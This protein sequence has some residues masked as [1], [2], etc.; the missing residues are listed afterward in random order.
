MAGRRVGDM[1][2]K[3]ENSPNLGKIHYRVSKI[4]MN[5]SKSNFY[6]L[7]IGEV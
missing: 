4:I 5:F 6:E 2:S 1:K 3:F 7:S